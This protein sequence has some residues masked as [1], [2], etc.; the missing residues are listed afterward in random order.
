MTEEVALT[1]NAKATAEDMLSRVE[2]LA[3]KVARLQIESDSDAGVA[4][5]HLQTVKAWISGCEEQ[6]TTL[7]KPLNETIKRINDMF[8][9]PRQ[10]LEQLRDAI[11]KPLTDYQAR[12]RAEA[13]AA[14][15]ERLRLAAE[16]EAKRRAADEAERKRQE[17]IL[18]RQL[19]ND[20]T[21]ELWNDGQGHGDGCTM[22]KNADGYLVIRCAPE[23]P[24]KAPPPA[25]LEGRPKAPTMVQ[26][27]LE[28]RAKSDAE[29]AE[30][31]AAQ[32]IVPSAKASVYTEGRLTSRRRWKSEIVNP[33]LVPSQY[34]VIDEKLIRAAVRAGEREIPGVRIW[35]EEEVL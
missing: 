6:R 5:E 29:A 16:A 24:T 10:K 3:A 18:H 9:V 27:I 15:R 26:R 30:R 28:E 19:H 23:C 25:P 13:E 11:R 7:V 4:A 22:E 12:K 21:A 8:R 33:E 35:Q 14:E 31:A 17:A 34:R 32:A 20:E 1:L 2:Q